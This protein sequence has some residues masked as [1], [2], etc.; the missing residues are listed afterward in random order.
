MGNRKL[1]VI[2]KSV[3]ANSHKIFFFLLAGVDFIVGAIVG[4][5]LGDS[6]LYDLFGSIL[7]ASIW[8]FLDSS[9]FIALTIVSAIMCFIVAA[10]LIVYVK[11]YRYEFY[12]DRI[13]E[14]YGLIARW[15]KQTPM[16]PIIGVY[17]EQS[18]WGRIFDYA[19]ITL[20]KIGSTKWS[21][22][23]MY[24]ISEASAVKECLEEMISRTKDDIT[25][26]LG[27]ETV[28]LSK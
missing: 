6:F 21:N 22:F 8:A 27:N 17:M 13:I 24:R 12:E 7:P 23:E 2:E 25:S 15:E 1:F 9:A 26:V 3:F 18:F 20:E 14:K 28:A 4:A 5:Q 19:T 11:T 16:T 10:I